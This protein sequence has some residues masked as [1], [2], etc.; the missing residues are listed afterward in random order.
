[1]E[2]RFYDCCAAGRRL[3]QLLHQRVFYQP[4]NPHKSPVA[5][6]EACVRLRSSRKTCVRGLSDTPRFLDGATASQ[7]DAGFAS[8]YRGF[9]GVGRLIKNPLTEQR[10]WFLRRFI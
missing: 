3:R 10:V 4:S 1:R 8:C 5:A 9:V 6:G 7:P 2:H